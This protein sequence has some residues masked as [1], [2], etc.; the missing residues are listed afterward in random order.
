[1]PYVPWA[2]GD[3]PPHCL[4][5]SRLPRPLCLPSALPALLPSTRPLGAPFVDGPPCSLSSPPQF[6]AIDKA[7]GRDGFK[8]VLLLRLSPLLPFAISNYLYGE[9]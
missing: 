7:I 6:A 5:L 1:M 4:T 9:R 3:H 2:R 8:V